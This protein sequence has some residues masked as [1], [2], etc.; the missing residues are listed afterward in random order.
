[1]MASSKRLAQRQE[2][3]ESYYT[4]EEMEFIAAVRKY[5]VDSGHKFPTFTQI[6][7]VAKSLGY[8]KVTDD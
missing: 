6:L 7:G 2:I 1:M 5:Q 4:D 8:R 3:S